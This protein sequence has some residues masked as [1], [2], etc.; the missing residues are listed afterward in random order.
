MSNLQL[1]TLVYII[2]HDVLVEDLRLYNLGTIGS[3][4]VRGWIK[5]NGQRIDATK[6]GVDAAEMYLKAGPNIKQ[7]ESDISD[8]VRMFLHLRAMQMP[9]RS[10]DA[11]PTIVKKAG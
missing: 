10:A 5:R 4:L 3:L 11:G 1:G 7:H 9:A 6:E 2:K 8:R